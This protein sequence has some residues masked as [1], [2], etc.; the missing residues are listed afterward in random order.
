MTVHQVPDKKQVPDK[1]RDA[2]KLLK[3]IKFGAVS[4]NN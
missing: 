4:Y 3:F 1:W 2:R